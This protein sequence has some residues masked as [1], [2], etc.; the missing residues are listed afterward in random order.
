MSSSFGQII[1]LIDSHTQW[2]ASQQ[3]ELFKKKIH[4]MFILSQDVEM[5]LY[6]YKLHCSSSAWISPLI[7]AFRGI[8]RK[9]TDVFLL[10]VLYNPGGFDLYWEP[11]PAFLLCSSE[12]KV[13]Q[14]Q[15]LS[16]CFQRSTK[17]LLLWEK[18]QQP[19]PHWF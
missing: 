3:L 19:M 15:A 11:L 1:C 8:F 2:S 17:S 14:K 6:G 9:C 4:S 10:H 7:G 5:I 12:R 18:K 16:S 13:R